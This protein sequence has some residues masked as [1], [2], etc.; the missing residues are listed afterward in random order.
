MR[1]TFVGGIS[2]R[3]RQRLPL[4]RFKV[5]ALDIVTSSKV[6]DAFDIDK[7]PQQVRTRYGEGT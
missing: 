3:R 1:S 2:T 5:R 6:R 4:T 7:E